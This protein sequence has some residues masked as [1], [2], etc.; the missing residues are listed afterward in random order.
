MNNN[1]LNN[2]AKN[3]IEAEADRMQEKLR[4]EIN[5]MTPAEKDAYFQSI[6]DAL[7]EAFNPQSARKRLS[8]PSGK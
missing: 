2:R 5:S 7:K 6:A 3:P 8:R 1:T 4:A